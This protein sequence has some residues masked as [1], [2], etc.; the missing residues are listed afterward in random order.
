MVY[1][2]MVRSNI[3][4]YGIF[5]HGKVEYTGIWY[6]QPWYGRIDH[7]VVYSTLVRS[8]T[9]ECGIFNLGKVEYTGIWYIQPW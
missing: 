2:T 9:P 1:S 7:D 3:P 4:E 5:N 8:N 6:I